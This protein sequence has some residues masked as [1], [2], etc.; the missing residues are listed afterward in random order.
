MNDELVAAVG[1]VVSVDAHPA[2]LLYLRSVLQ[3]R[4]VNIL[5]KLFAKF[6]DVKHGVLCILLKFLMEN[7]KNF[8]RQKYP[9]FIVC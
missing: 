4:K 2:V 8:P 9:K 3:V 6:C 1:G 5:K 7:Y